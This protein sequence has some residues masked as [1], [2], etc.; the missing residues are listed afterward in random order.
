VNK[1]LETIK[2]SINEIDLSELECNLKQYTNEAIGSI[3]QPDLSNYLTKNHIYNIPQVQP[4]P[5]EENSNQN[6]SLFVTK[7]YVDN[8]VNNSQP[9]LSN[10]LTMN[11]VYVQPVLSDLI[12]VEVPDPDGHKLIPKKYLDSVMPV[13]HN[14]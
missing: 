4:I 2:I 5:G 13:S 9:N 3:P 8:F 6:G 11:D 7:S 10:Y 1:E 12:V 14:K